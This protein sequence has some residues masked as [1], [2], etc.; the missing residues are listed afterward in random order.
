MGFSQQ[1]SNQFK[2]MADNLFNDKIDVG[3]PLPSSQPQQSEFT[4]VFG[5]VGAEAPLIAPPAVVSAQRDPSMLDDSH[6]TQQLP[7]MQQSPVSEQTPAGHTPSEFTMIMQGGYGQG[8][9][10]TG[11][12]PATGAAAS[13]AGASPIDLNIAP[14]GAAAMPY[15]GSASG[16][17]AG[18]HGN[19]SQ[20]GA[21]VNSALGSAHMSGPKIPAADFQAPLPGKAAANKKLMLF[22]ILLGVLTVLLIIVIMILMKSK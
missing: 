7:T 18:V 12:S 10:S 11:P 14:M 9:P 19:V 16:S 3:R 15:L 1:P 20:H 4:K 21:S 6:G 5:A 2:E 13:G 8:K 22:F 17:L